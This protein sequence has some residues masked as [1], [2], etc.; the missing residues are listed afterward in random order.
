MSSRR[1]SPA[2][3]A[4]A[5]STVVS[6][7]LNELK[8]QITALKSSST[9]DDTNLE[10]ST[11]GNDDAFIGLRNERVIHNQVHAQMLR[12]LSSSVD[13]YCDMNKRSLDHFGA[14]PPIS[15]RGASGTGA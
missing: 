15:A 5:V 10:V 12:L 4:A 8:A 2:A 14:L 1:R 6:T 7:S 3:V 13:H 11:V 9:V